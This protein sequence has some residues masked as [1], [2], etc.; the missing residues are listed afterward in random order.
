[1]SN[2]SCSHL[3]LCPRCG[4]G[5]SCQ[6]S[7]AAR[8]TSHQAQTR[9]MPAEPCPSS[10]NINKDHLPGAV[11]LCGAL[12]CCTQ[13]TPGMASAAVKERLTRLG[14]GVLKPAA[15]LA[16]L[17]AALRASAGL[18]SLASIS[19]VPGGSAAAVGALAGVDA[20]AV[21]AVNPWRWRTYLQHMQVG[22]MPCSKSHGWQLLLR[23][24]S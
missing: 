16:A 11:L 20:A 5:L 17:A 21:V 6:P 2:V 19:P 13:I 18:A 15:G 7:Y 1:M 12:R 8:R 23:Q 24:A 4:S 3:M 22:W 10:S 9:G 14:Q